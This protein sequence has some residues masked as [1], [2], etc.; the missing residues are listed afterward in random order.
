MRGKAGSPPGLPVPQ[1]PPWGA[2]SRSVSGAA[3]R[4]SREPRRVPA[5]GG[6]AARRGYRHRPRD[7]G[8]RCRAPGALPWWSPQPRRPPTCVSDVSPRD[9][10]A[11]K[12]KKQTREILVTAPCGPLEAVAFIS[13]P[14][15]VCASESAAGSLSSHGGQLASSL[16]VFISLFSLLYNT[17]LEQFLASL[18][19]SLVQSPPERTK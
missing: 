13:P 11:L 17:I 9:F 8:L 7:R 1:E 16:L 10:V 3:L 12:K 5:E 4:R 6:G 19:F 15:G 2:G 18:I 14:G